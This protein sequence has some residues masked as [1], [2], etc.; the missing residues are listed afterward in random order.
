MWNRGLM[1]EYVAYRNRVDADGG[2][3]DS[4]SL[5]RKLL[6][7]YKSEGRLSNIK[8]LWSAV[9]GTLVQSGTNPVQISKAYSAD[10]LTTHNDLAQATSLSQPFGVGQIQGLPMGLYN[11]NGGTRF[12]THSEINFVASAIKRS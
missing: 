11:P 2:D 5:T 7:F 4:G 9:G 3:I 1:P 6:K 8:L 10:S 12:M